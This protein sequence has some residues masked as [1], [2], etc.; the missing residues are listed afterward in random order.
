MNCEGLVKMVKDWYEWCLAFMN[1]DKL[2]RNT[3]VL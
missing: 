3:I 2:V 1:C